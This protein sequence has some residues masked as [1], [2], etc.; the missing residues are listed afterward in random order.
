LDFAHWNRIYHSCSLHT[1]YVMIILYISK[2][3]SV[4]FIYSISTIM[5]Y[6]IVCLCLQRWVRLYRKTTAEV[7]VRTTNGV[8]AANK[9][10]KYH[11]LDRGASKKSLTNIATVL[12]QTFIPGRRNKYVLKL[13]QNNFI[14]LCTF[15]F[16]GQCTL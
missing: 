9:T 8:E 3:Y 12:T 5:E 13:N 1:E 14:C 15:S 7:Y 6:Q 4:W 11:C 2:T 10:L 16:D